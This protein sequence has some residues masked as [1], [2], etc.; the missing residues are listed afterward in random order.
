[1]T[2]PDTI[3]T[4]LAER[5]IEA[6]RAYHRARE[7]MDAVRRQL[8][9]ESGYADFGHLP[10]HDWDSMLIGISQ[11]RVLAASF[12]A[13][14]AELLKT[15]MDRDGVMLAP[16]QEPTPLD[17]AIRRANTALAEVRTMLGGPRPRH[18]AVIHD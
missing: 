17:A 9:F 16:L 8:D 2:T 5:V 7:A 11:A 4:E 10:R 3:P 13:Q 15:G 12:D 1:M 14:I 18:R 6:R